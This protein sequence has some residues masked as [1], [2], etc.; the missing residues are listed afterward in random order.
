MNAERRKRLRTALK[1]MRAA[2]ET[3]EAVANEEDEARENLPENLQESET[4]LDMEQASESLVLISDE[5]T[6]IADDLE[7]IADGES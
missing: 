7:V 5:L 2:Q 6:T 1:S 4:A 3:I